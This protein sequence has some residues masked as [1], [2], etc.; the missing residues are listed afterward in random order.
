VSDALAR[1]EMVRHDCG[2][3]VVT[4]VGE[5]DLSNAGEFDRLL[6]AAAE[7]SADLVIDLAEVEYMDSHGMRVLQRLV[8]RHQTGSLRLILVSRRRSVV[9]ELLA[10]TR[11]GDVVPVLEPGT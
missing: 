1:V 5:V 6:T 3:A 4:V 7:D 10:I 2:Q 8:R 11:I 9:G